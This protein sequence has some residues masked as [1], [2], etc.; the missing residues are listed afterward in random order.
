[1]AK[2][3]IF[4]FYSSVLVMVFLPTAGCTFAEPIVITPVK[5]DPDPLDGTR[6][7]LIAFEG[8]QSAPI[9]PDVVHPVIKFDAGVLDFDAGCNSVSGHYL[10]ENNRITMTFMEQTL[11]SCQ[12]KPEVMEIEERFVAAMETFQTYVIED[13]RLRIR[14]SAG[15]LLFFRIFG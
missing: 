9:I 6:W 11:V 14:Y 3:A 15:Q 10:I 2:F 8:D 5:S 7:E 4:C 1:M 12:D 13:D